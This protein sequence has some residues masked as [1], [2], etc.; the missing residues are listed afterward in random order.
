MA[1]GDTIELL[2]E[3]DS[4]IKMGINAIDE[5]LD[6]IENHNL[7]A[8]LQ[9]SKEKH[10]EIENEIRELLNTYGDS[11]KEPSA[12]AK[13]MSWIKTNMKMSLNESDETA[14]DLITDG[15]NMG[16]KTLQK[17]L[18]EYERAEDKA[19]NLAKKIITTEESL[20]TDLRSYL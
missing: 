17:Y 2:K 9:K 14:S 8:I 3:C 11:G 15:C 1:T 16:I 12:A 20:L 10:I 5:V 19:K 7:E 18:N 4:G 13:S 6:R